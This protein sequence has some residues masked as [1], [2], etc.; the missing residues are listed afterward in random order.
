MMQHQDKLKQSFIL[1]EIVVKKSPWNAHIIVSQDILGGSGVMVAKI[2]IGM[3][4]QASKKV[5]PAS[6]MVHAAGKF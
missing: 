2:Y 3:E 5:V 6:T 4:T 1:Q